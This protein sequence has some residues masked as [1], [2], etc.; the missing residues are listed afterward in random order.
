MA[1]GQRLFSGTDQ[2][3]NSSTIH[4]AVMEPGPFNS[5]FHHVLVLCEV[6]GFRRLILVISNLSMHWSDSRFVI[7]ANQYVR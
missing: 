2:M 6:F 3:F 5:K 4:Q 1:S 7:L